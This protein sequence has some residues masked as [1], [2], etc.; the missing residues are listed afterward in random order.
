[1]EW[2]GATSGDGEKCQQLTESPQVFPSNAEVGSVFPAL[3][4]PAGVICI[5]SAEG[6]DDEGWTAI[7]PE[8]WRKTFREQGL[9]N[10]SSVWIQDSSHDNNSL[11]TKQGEWISSVNETDWI[12][13]KNLCQLESEEEQVKIPATANTALNSSFSHKEM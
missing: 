13:V 4:I 1:M 3:A 9:R 2:S 8:D 10:G 11:L 5:S 6:T 12:Q 7:P